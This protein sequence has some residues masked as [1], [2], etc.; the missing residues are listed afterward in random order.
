MRSFL[1]KIYDFFVLKIIKLKLLIRYGTTD[2]FNDIDIE[3]NSSCNRQCSYCP[4][5]ISNRGAIK[6][7]KLM[8]AE[9][10]KKVVDELAELKFTG[11][12]SPIFY[13]EPLLRKDLVELMKYTREKLPKVDI[14]MTTNGDLL[15][16]EKYV[17]LV[18][19]GVNKFLITQHGKEMS[20][21]VK[22]VFEFIKKNP[23]K[24]VKIIYGKFEEGTP[25]YNR[26]GL[27]KPDTVD[28][29][30]RCLKPH[31]PLIIDWEGNVVL[32]CND[33][34]SSV[35]FGNVENEK[36]IDIWNSKA[37]TKTRRDLRNKNFTL[38]ICKKCVGIE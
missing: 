7:E 19:V 36:L 6:N 20:D 28:Y 11:R 26:G 34:F 21:N 2:F 25:L 14:K 8:K 31:N 16:V 5:S 24:K 15:T 10:Y 9:V 18:D 4:N 30:P 3:V 29:N 27:L 17:E 35:K 12:L 32:C 1:K 22:S 38:P 37:Y 23:D 33:Y 13:G